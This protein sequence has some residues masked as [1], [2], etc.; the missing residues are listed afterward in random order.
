MKM[1]DSSAKIGSYVAATL[2]IPGLLLF[3]F[4]HMEG[5]G[6]RQNA[7]GQRLV[8]ASTPETHPELTR[9]EMAEAYGKLPLAFEKNMGQTNPQVQYLSHGQGY[10]LFLTPQEAVLSL[11]HAKAIGVS[12]SNRSAYVRAVREAN[13]AAKTSV[14]RMQ[15]AGANPAAEITGLDKLARKTDYFTGNNPKDW[16]TDVPSY[17]RVEYREVYPGVDAIFYG[18]QKR[19]EYDFVVAPGADPRAIALN[20]EGA[21]R[22]RVD[23]HGNLAM[24]IAQGTIELEKPAM[25]QVVNGERREVAGNYVLRGDNRVAFDVSGYDPSQTLVIDPVL[26]YSTYL[27]GSSVGDF[28][29]GIAVDGNGDAFVTGGTFSATFPAGT[30]GFNSTSPDPNVATNGAAFVSEL[31]PTGTQELYF[32]YLSGDGGEYALGVA[33]DPVANTNCENVGTPSYC[34]YVTGQ[35]FST[36]YPVNSVITPYNAG[37]G[38][39]GDAFVTKLNP[40]ASGNNSLLYSSYLASDGAG[41][42][43]ASIAV[44]ANQHA[45]ITGLALAGPGA[46][47]NFPVVNGAQ[48]T[49]GSANG[50]AFLTVVD[51]TASSNAVIYSTYLGGD[52]ANFGTSTLASG[53]FGFGVTVDSNGVAYI[54]GTT[55]SSNFPD[56]KGFA[57]PPAGNTKGVAFVSA[58]NTASSGVGSL[59]YSTYLGGSTFDEGTAIASGGGSGVVFV[60]GKTES[61]NFPVTQTGATAGKFPS[62]PS[63]SGVAFVT[64]INT[65]QTTGSPTYSVLLGGSNGDSG[66]GI[67]VDGQGN[68]I[69]AGATQSSDFAVTPGAFRASLGTAPG[70]AFIAKIKPAGAGSSDLLYSTYFG[71]NGQPNLPDQAQG[72]AVDSLGNAYVTGVTYSADLP[73]APNPGAFQATMPGGD[74]SAAFVAKLTL[75]PTL[76]VSPLSIAFG[77]QGITQMSAAQIVTLTNN[78]DSVIGLIIPLPA[79]TGANPGDF[80]AAPAA[81]GSIAACTTSLSA[82]SS[83]AIGVTFTPTLTAAESATL[84]ISFTYNNGVVPAASGSEAVGLSGTGVVAAPGATV[85]PASPLTFNGQLVTTTSSAQTVTVTNSGNANLTFSA[86]PSISGTNSTDFTIASGTTCSVST[87]V[88]AGN[89]CIINITF[90]PPAGAAGARSA[91]LTMADNA[92]GSPHPEALA[93]TAWDFSLSA[94]SATVGSNGTAS[95]PVTVTGIGGFAGPVTLSCSASIP[96]GTCTAPATPVTATGTANVTIATNAFVVP[97]TPGQ[98]PPISPLQIVLCLLG[99]TLL[100]LFPIARRARTRL[101]L[102][103]VAVLFVVL[104]GCANTP[105]TSAGQYTVTI[106]GTSGSVSHQTTATVTVK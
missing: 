86:A 103:G 20:V 77:N 69:V 9:A 93:G 27:G 17:S 26:D 15:F 18:N 6:T 100:F 12:P 81:S 30:N 88:A 52:D 46:P 74:V 82:G 105:P 66:F 38:G 39:G 35:T 101:G 49:L 102:A 55:V 96:H 3:A 75:Q 31:D 13:R 8:S 78:T 14:V 72:V 54:V 70:D 104:A 21:R 90:A 25:Y 53:D 98:T 51:T 23:A 57:G 106:T 45:Y 24:S 2:F 44:D 83:C 4:V 61:S 10:E 91:V 48:T 37:P 33:V 32:S 11:R 50:N 7:A 87:P 29:Q 16:R 97:S 68:V 63:S 22:L 42:I 89:S 47:P 92:S 76:A 84:N 62:P 60:T 43:G 71:G 28:A 99:V 36:N 56:I 85:M 59:I 40:Y 34:V 80:A 94:Q 73:L 41:D 58:I 1:R 65:T 19:L 67:R 5:H 64:E 79:L 95:V